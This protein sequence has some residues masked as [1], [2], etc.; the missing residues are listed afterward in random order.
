[1]AEPVCRFHCLGKGNLTVRVPLHHLYIVEH[2]RIPVTEYPEVIFPGQKLVIFG[3]YKGYPILSGK[4]VTML[5]NFH[6]F[7]FLHAYAPPLQIKI[8]FKIRTG[9]PL[10]QAFLQIRVI[11]PVQ[12]DESQHGIG[13][14]AVPSPGE[15]I[16]QASFRIMRKY[17]IQ[18]DSHRYAVVMKRLHCLEPFPESGCPWLQLLPEFLVRISNRKVHMDELFPHYVKLHIK[19]VMKSYTLCKVN[20]RN[21]YK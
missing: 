19:W 1:M 17:G 13:S 12:M 3:C 18:K 14:A 6:T 9:L 5:C 4:P 21:P 16:L 7:V 11:A 20:E 10:R 15:N 2:K 8:P